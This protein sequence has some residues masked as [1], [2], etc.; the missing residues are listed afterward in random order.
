MW[1]GVSDEERR[2][3]SG[4][5]VYHARRE[6]LKPERSVDLSPDSGNIDGTDEIIHD[7]G[8]DT[9]MVFLVFSKSSMYEALSC[10]PLLCPAMSCANSPE[11]EML[12]GC[13]RCRKGSLSSMFVSHWLCFFQLMFKPQMV[14]LS[15]SEPMFTL[16][17]RACS[18]RCWNV[19]ESW[20]SFEKSYSQFI[21]NIVLRSC[22]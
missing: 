1:L 8:V 11:N 16:L 5:M 4:S 10:V 7:V 17:V 22:P 15:G 19:P 21:P 20:K 2:V 6:R 14:L 9:S 18:E 12:E 3:K 13:V